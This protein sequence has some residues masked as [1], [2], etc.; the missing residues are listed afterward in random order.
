M[1]EPDVP[2]IEK[3]S[4]AE[5]DY[6]MLVKTRPGKQYAVQRELR[7]RI[8]DCFEKNKI[9]PGPSPYYVISASPTPLPTK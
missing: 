4:G 2:G 5:V 3:V 1:S 9:K 6:L 8:K 7:R